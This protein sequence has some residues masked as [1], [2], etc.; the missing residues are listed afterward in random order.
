MIEPDDKLAVIAA[1]VD[2]HDD[3]GGVTIIGFGRK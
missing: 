1:F 2:T 3:I